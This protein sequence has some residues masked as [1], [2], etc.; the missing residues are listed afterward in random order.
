MDV[1]FIVG[2]YAATA[3]TGAVTVVT[4]AL[5]VRWFERVTPGR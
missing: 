2:G 5:S 4:I 1:L 3:A